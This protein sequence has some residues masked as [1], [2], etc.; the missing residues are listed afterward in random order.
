MP[1]MDGRE[2]LRAIRADAR[3][4]R[5]PGYLV[6]ADVDGRNQTESDATHY[7]TRH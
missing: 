5:L 3:L 4:S 6:T 7:R 1:E 2:L